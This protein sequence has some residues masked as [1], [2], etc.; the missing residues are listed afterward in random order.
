MAGIEPNPPAIIALNP[1]GTGLLVN[2]GVTLQVNQRVAVNSQGAGLDQHGNSVGSGSGPAASILTTALLQAPRVDV[3]GGVDN[4]TLFQPYPVNGPSPLFAGKGATKPDP[5]SSLSVPTTQ[6]G[7]NATQGNGQGSQSISPGQTLVLPPGNY[8]SISVIGGNATFAGGI[9]QLTSNGGNNDRQI[10]ISSGNVDFYPGVYPSIE[11]DGGTVIFHSDYYNNNRPSNYMPNA[12]IYVIRA[13]MPNSAL[14]I[15]GGTITGN[16][17][18]F[19]N[20][21][22]HYDPT[23][24]S[25]D[26]SDWSNYGSTAPPS[27]LDTFGQVNI[28]GTVNFTPISNSN[29]IFNNVGLFQRP[30]NTQLLVLNG[31][32]PWSQFSGGVILYAKWA[33]LNFQMMTP[34][35]YNG[36]I[37]VGSLNVSTNNG[38]GIV[39]INYGTNLPLSY[40]VYLVE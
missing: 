10:T 27:N 19:Y 26:A 8:T 1:T 40:R 3:A 7:V 2:S 13:S 5:C 28:T 36:Q 34:T 17:V 25:P 4:P 24:G 23:T 38:S 37:V 9:Y 33:K 35:T 6:N 29:S 14:T 31:Q 21:G 16:N 22:Q 32:N 18:M 15:T 11:I 12:G 20:T 30:A 39:K